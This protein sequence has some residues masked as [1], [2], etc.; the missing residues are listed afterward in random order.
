M[1]TTLQRLLLEVLQVNNQLLC[2]Q[3]EYK[4]LD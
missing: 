3:N 2:S 4:W 1:R